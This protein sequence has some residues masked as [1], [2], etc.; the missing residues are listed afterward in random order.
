[1]VRIKVHSNRSCACPNR[2]IRI[3]IIRIDFVLV[4]IA[5]VLRRIWWSDQD[6]QVSEGVSEQKSIRTTFG[7]NENFGV[8]IEIFQSY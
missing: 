4:R 2:V 3:S 1:V 6:L 8:R 7:S 5:F